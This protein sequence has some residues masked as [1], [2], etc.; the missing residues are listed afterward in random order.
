MTD[1][2]KT[3]PMKTVCV[4]RFLIDVPDKAIVTY[5]GASLSGWTI[6]SWEETEEDFLSTQKEI[7]LKLKAEKN[8]RG[9]ISLEQI[10]ELKYENL[11]GKILLFNRRSAPEYS[12]GEKKSIILFQSMR[13]FGLEV[14]PIN[15]RRNM[16]Q[17]TKLMRC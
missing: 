10:R 13:L 5:R 1:H 3:M 6:S 16:L 15:L 17:I 4:G 12:G 14:S 9:G 11:H 8:S 7:E 2:I